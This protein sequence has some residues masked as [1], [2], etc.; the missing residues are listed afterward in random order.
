[1]IPV[2]TGEWT[3][4][5]CQLELTEPVIYKIEAGVRSGQK[6]QIDDV[7]FIDRECYQEH[8]QVTKYSDPSKSGHVNLV[9]KFQ[10]LVGF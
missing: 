4:F 2:P 9:E 3:Y 7:S 6:L 5:Q 1:M 10:Q 8:F